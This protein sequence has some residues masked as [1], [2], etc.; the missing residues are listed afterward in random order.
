MW[1]VIQ[2]ILPIFLVVLVVSQYAIP[3]LLGSPTWW[4]FRRTA[5]PAVTEVPPTLTDEIESV[6]VEAEVVKTKVRKVRTK[7]EKNLKTA[8]DLKKDADNII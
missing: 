4:L 3:T 6:K 2:E 7:V 8:E 5:K 1:K